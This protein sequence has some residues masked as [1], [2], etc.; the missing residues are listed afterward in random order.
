MSA[1]L[2]YTFALRPWTSISSGMAPSSSGSDSISDMATFSFSYSSCSLLS[3][4]L[5]LV[6]ASSSGTGE[7]T[8]GVW[9]SMVEI[10]AFA[11]SL[12]RPGCRLWNMWRRES[13][14][15]SEV[16]PHRRF[17]LGFLV[18]SVTVVMLAVNLFAQIIPSL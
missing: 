7:R 17:S 11:A 8:W 1:Q 4:T 16:G 12:S 6:L 13:E 5:S 15:T 2:R 18:R 14:A 10:D 3:L 9:R